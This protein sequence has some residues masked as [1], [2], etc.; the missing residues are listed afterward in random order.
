MERTIP[1]FEFALAAYAATHIE[2]GFEAESRERKPATVE[3]TDYPPLA[4]DRRRRLIRLWNNVL[5]PQ[6]QT[7]VC[8]WN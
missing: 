4:S 7:N 6:T 8:E 5:A 2:D 1:V 3:Q